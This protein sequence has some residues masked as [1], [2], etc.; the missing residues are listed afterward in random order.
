MSEYTEEQLA[1]MYKEVEDI[2][3]VLGALE[4]ILVDEE[5]GGIQKLDSNVIGI[6][7]KMLT[8]FEH[9]KV[10]PMPISKVISTYHDW[11]WRTY[12]L[13][14]QNQGRLKKGKLREHVIELYNIVATAKQVFAQ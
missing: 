11:A 2:R 4:K 14:Q 13:A 8:E 3:E 7:R 1:A 9:I 5:K 6:D 12:C 10:T